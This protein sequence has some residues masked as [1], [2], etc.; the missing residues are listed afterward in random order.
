MVRFAL[1][2]SVR[3]LVAV[4]CLGWLFPVSSLPAA[5][6]KSIRA[7]A[8]V[9]VAFDD[10]DHPGAVLVKKIAEPFSAK[11][12]NGPSRVPSPFWNQSGR[13]ALRFD[14]A[15][16]Q[17]VRLVDIPYTSRPD[18]VTLSFFFVS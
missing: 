12:V 17:S 6:A 1:S 15:K 5:G 3:I 9:S 13:S 2:R 18:A 14:A 8:A 10:A 7:G 16:R 11:L 4:F